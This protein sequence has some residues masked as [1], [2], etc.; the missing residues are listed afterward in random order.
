[1][2]LYPLKFEP[3]LR[4]MI[5][6]GS[7]I[8]KFKEITPLEAGIGESWE[9]SDIENSMSIVANGDLKGKTLHE[10]I[11]ENG[12]S[13]MGNHV[14]ERFG[15]R[16]PL[17]VKFIDACNDLSIQVHPDD[18]L[19]GERHNSFGK[20]EMWYVINAREGAGLYSGF[21]AQITPEEYVERVNSN[22]FMDVLQRYQVKAGDVFFLPAGRV[23]AIGSG[24][25]IAEIQQTSDVTYRIYDYNR[26]DKDGNR[27]ELHTELAKDA[28][29][30]T[31]LSDYQTQYEP[32]ENEAV[33]LV[34]CKYFHTNL[35]EI[36]EP[37]ERKMK[38]YDSFVIY[39]CNEGKGEIED[40]AG[41]KVSV[42]QGDSI[43][44]PASMADLTIRPEGDLKL[45]EVYIP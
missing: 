2:N 8:C 42:C 33:E 11:T 7:D 28:I 26:L 21:S 35:L 14:Y 25:F 9:I 16:F 30:Y 27:R 41:N 1:M 44:V 23:H 22:T 5:W 31:V 36:N 32:K 45:L 37:A 39:I 10:V 18:E 12:A 6:G 40:A 4:P 24:L 13:F 34:E 3:L 15:N 19:A 20:T 38:Q 43:L 17:L 29:D